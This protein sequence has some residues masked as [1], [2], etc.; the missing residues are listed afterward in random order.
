MTFLYIYLTIVNI[1]A[2]VLMAVDKYRAHNHRWRVPERYLY[3]LAVLGGS[4]GAVAG[5]LLLW[6]KVRDNMFMIGLPV[7]L[8]VHLLLVIMIAK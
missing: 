8:A 3:L 2:F 5:M 4:G 1:A 7:L 6:H